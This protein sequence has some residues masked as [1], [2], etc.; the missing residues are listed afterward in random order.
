[1]RHVLALL[2]CRG[3]GDEGQGEHGLD[4]RLG[5]LACR[6]D[7]LLISQVEKV[8]QPVALLQQEESFDATQPVEQLLLVD[9]E[10]QDLLRRRGVGFLDQLRINAR[11][12]RIGESCRRWHLLL[13]RFPVR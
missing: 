2:V 3:S 5:R 6:L 9:E 1:A 12:G 7:Q 13:R 8:H 4:A 11:V 10:L